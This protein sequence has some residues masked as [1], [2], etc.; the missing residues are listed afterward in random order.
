LNAEV[1]E[2]RREERRGEER[3]EK[4]REVSCKIT[5]GLDIRTEKLCERDRRVMY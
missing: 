2:P 1:E 3:R 4:R 5:A